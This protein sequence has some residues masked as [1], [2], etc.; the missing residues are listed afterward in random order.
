M[1][2]SYFTQCDSRWLRVIFGQIHSA[3]HI[4]ISPIKGSWLSS[5]A[6]ALSDLC[7]QSW[8][9]RATLVGCVRG[10]VDLACTSERD[11]QAF[12]SYHMPHTL[13]LTSTTHAH[14]E[15]SW[16]C[17]MDCNTVHCNEMMPAAH[18]IPVQSNSLKVSVYSR[19]PVLLLQ[20]IKAVLTMALYCKS[21]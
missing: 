5:C 3:H 11:T 14:T 2:E 7:W 1:P 16:L 17:K 10:Q 4:V 20:A 6:A 18:S 8:S 15:H 12:W 9:S 19:C 13:T 21:L